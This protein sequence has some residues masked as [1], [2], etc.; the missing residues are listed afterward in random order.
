M[1]IGKDEFLRGVESEFPNRNTLLHFANRREL[2]QE[3]DVSQFLKTP[4][5]LDSIQRMHLVY[6]FFS[7]LSVK[8][9][10]TGIANLLS[11]YQKS[12]KNILRNHQQEDDEKINILLNMLRFEKSLIQLLLEG[13]DLSK[14]S[15]SSH[16]VDN[17]KM[18]LTNQKSIVMLESRR[19]NRLLADYIA[20]IEVV[21]YLYKSLNF[22]DSRRSSKFDSKENKEFELNPVHLIKI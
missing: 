3:F 21:S 9:E 19:S 8:T 1:K 2:A 17:F 14:N 7:E 10:L 6:V 4:E 18:I 22:T 5:Y 12:M 16:M 13:S 11:D 15:I 20:L